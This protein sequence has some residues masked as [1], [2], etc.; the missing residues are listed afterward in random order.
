MERELKAL[1][2]T[3]TL[4]SY[5]GRHTFPQQIGRLMAA[6]IERYHADLC[7][8]EKIYYLPNGE[9]HPVACK[10]G[11]VQ[12][13]TVFSH[14]GIVA[15]LRAIQAQQITYLEFCDRI[16]A[17]GCISYVVS[18]AGRRA[19]YFG[20]SGDVYVEHFPKAT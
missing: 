17:A 9:S 4:Y 7:R 10:F 2:E 6:G 13:A 1:V 5:E 11:K 3:C 14:E 18:I 12:P 16:M 8:L 20:R 19:L 15:A